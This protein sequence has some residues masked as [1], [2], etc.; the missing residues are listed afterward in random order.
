MPRGS[1]AAVRKDSNQPA[2]STEPL[3]PRE[4]EPPPE[5]RAALQPWVDLDAVGLPGLW[6]WLRT[7]LPVIPTPPARDAR[8]TRTTRDVGGERRVHDLARA[9]VECAGDRARLN[10]RASEYYADNTVLARRIRAL[11]GML[12]ARGREKEPAADEET[13]RATERYLPHESSEARER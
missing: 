4:S 11:E 8:T 10:F 1:E 2:D 5:L 12:R 6:V 3:R 13:E 7:I 9:L